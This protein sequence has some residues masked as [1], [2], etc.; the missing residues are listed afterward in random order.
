V[1]ISN[2]VS[3][4]LEQQHGVRIAPG[5][6]GVCPFCRHE[7]FA[8]HKNDSLGKCFHSS[9]GRAI[10]SGSLDSGYNGSLYQILDEIKRDCHA[11]LIR[12]RDGNKAYAWDYLTKTRAIHPR[13]LFDLVELG[14]VPHD[15]DVNKVF[16]P[17]L[18]KIAERRKELDADTEAVQKKKEGRKSKG[19]TEQE[20]K[21]EKESE[22]LD[23]QERFLAERRD[24]LQER[25]AKTAG[26]V[27]FFHTDAHHRTLSIRFRKFE[28]K[29]FQSY[30]PFTGRTGLFG[31]SLFSHYQSE[32]RRKCNRLMI[33]EGEINLLQIHGLALRTAPETNG[34]NSPK[35]ANWIAATGS[36]NTQDAATIA[37]LLKTPGTVKPLV[38]CQDNDE[39]GDE[40][41]ANLSRTFTLEVLTP[42]KREQDVDEFI[43]G[44]EKDYAS[45]WAG[46]EELISKRR[47]ICRPWNALA[48]QI[49][50]ARQKHGEDDERRD[51]EINAEVKRIVIDDL[52]ERGEF[53]HE[54]SHGY[55]F[56][57]D[58]KRL[59]PL[60]DRDNQLSCLLDRYG[61]NPV[62]KAC[63]YTRKSLYIESLTKGKATQVHRLTWFDQQTHTLY[64]FNH[65]NQVYRI[66][67]DQIELVDNGTD[68]TLF[69]FDPR[70]EPFK[71][72]TDENL[73]D[74]FHH[75]VTAEIN[76]DSEG[77]LTRGEQQSLFNHWFQ[78]IFFGSILPTRPLLGFIGP[79]GSGKSYTLRRVG[80]LLFGSQFEV[81]NLPASEGDFDAITTNTYYCA[82]DNADSKVKWLPD[83]LAICATG[84]TVSKR[85][86]YTTNSLVNYPIDCFVGITSRTPHF[87][88][89]DVAD[90]MLLHHVKR[91]EDGQYR[92]EHELKAAILKDRNRIMTA[93]V[94]QLQECIAALKQTEGRT[95]RTSF[96]MADFA[97]F[98]LRLADARGR[99]H[100]VEAT[101]GRMQEEQSAFTLEGD[102]LID[103]LQKWL[104]TETNHNKKVTASDLFKELRYLAEKANLPF[105]Y[106]NGRSLGQR[107]S[108]IESNLKSVVNLEV[109]PDKK[110]RQ[111]AYCFWP[112]E[113]GAQWAGK[114][115]S[116]GIDDLGDSCH[117]TYWSERL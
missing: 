111:K 72:A 18:E 98:C 100:E 17:H 20:K 32:Q 78:S 44:F 117:S 59:I 85:L 49:F 63:E 15:Y 66:T 29:R 86:Y 116:A 25:F 34:A 94:R 96:R 80:M 77:Q 104:E 14:A 7:C 79:K 28:G 40:A 92:S 22:R 103:L 112:K 73:G 102:C 30:V 42:P 58:D 110:K 1:V 9:C 69:I 113:E 71:L 13:V 81:T 89:D 88:R 83:R 26:W 37:A 45:A 23:T 57:S 108:H 36:A 54:H 82:F 33:V 11:E 74:L 51:F 101:F 91:F 87:N 55:Y 50:R 114:Q 76:F 105:D 5:R 31:H 56:L 39:A 67:A 90:R 41:V 52:R 46:L 60:D 70:N 109:K 16:A 65:A 8:V 106:E 38:V 61:L 2:S 95:Y 24:E 68:G 43:R 19:K 84:G 97:V 35:Y 47:L 4:H 6:K 75:A 107:L 21:I 64:L 12:Q 115:E 93:V 3:A 10:T 53:Y 27:A 62:E 99:R 48:E